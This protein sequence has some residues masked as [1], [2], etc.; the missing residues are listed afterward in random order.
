MNLTYQ[1]QHRMKNLNYLM[2]YILCQVF[3]IIF[4]IYLKKHAEKTANPSIRKWIIKIENRFRF[5]IKTGYYLEILTPGTIKLLESAKIKITQHEN[6]ENNSYLQ[7]WRVLYT[8][9]P[10]KSCGQLIDISPKTFYF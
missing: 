8:F 4:N 7:N 5:K 6:G 3:K 1:L 10:D 2:D 9:V